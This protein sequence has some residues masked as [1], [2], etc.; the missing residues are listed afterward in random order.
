MQVRYTVEDNPARKALASALSKQIYR[1]QPLIRLIR[2]GDALVLLPFLA[3]AAYFFFETGALI[4]NGITE[5]FEPDEMPLLHQLGWMRWAML[6]GAYLVML[7]AICL[8]PHLIYRLTQRTLNSLT[9]G[10]NVLEIREDGLYHAGYYGH[11][12][13]HYSAVR[14]VI[15][16]LRG[17]VVVRIDRGYAHAVPHSAFADEAQ[18]QQFTQLL[19][20]KAGLAQPA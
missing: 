11:T 17:F 9:K 2:L 3:L 6:L 7:Y 16:D 20:S 19:R 4:R 14:Q 15:D 10:D 13:L 5:W 8:R 1:G 12:V 18:R